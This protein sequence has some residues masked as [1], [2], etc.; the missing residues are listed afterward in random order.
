[1]NAVEFDNTIEHPNLEA[2]RTVT[3]HP[4][5]SLAGLFDNIGPSNFYLTSNRETSNRNNN[6][7]AGP[8]FVADT[9]AYQSIERKDHTGVP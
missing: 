8:T 3:H 5:A 7:G 6:G 4:G 2:N 9:T 1:M